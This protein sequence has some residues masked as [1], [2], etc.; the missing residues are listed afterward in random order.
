MNLVLPLFLSVLLG[1]ISRHNVRNEYETASSNIALLVLC[2]SKK[3]SDI[4]QLLQAASGA[5]QAAMDE[6]EQQTREVLAGQPVTT[7]IFPLQAR[8]WHTANE[9]QPLPKKICNIHNYG[10]P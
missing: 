10:L 7:N 4:G 9:M 5:G 8:F 2:K 1:Y 3:A 6:L